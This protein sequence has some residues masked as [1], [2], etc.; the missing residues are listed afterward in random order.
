M[1]VSGAAGAARHGS[2]AAALAAG[3]KAGAAAG[4]CAPEIPR[5]VYIPPPRGARQ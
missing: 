4:A 5:I 3:G 2:R 1:R